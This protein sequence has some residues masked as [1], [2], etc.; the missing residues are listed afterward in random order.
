[1]NDHCT[2]C[3]PNNDPQLPLVAAVIVT[4]IAK[5]IIENRETIKAQALRVKNWM[6]S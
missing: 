5:Y 2:S 4:N 3:C 1:M 6:K